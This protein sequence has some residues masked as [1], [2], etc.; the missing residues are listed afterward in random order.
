LRRLP[1]A[2]ETIRARVIPVFGAVL[3]LIASTGCRH[4]SKGSSVTVPRAESSPIIPESQR[5]LSTLGALPVIVLPVQ[6]LRGADPM[7]WTEQAGPAKAYLAKVDE[8]IAV[9]LGDRG[10]RSTWVFP[11]DLVRSARRNPGYAADPYSLASD[12][13]RAGER[14]TDQPLMEP[15]ASQLRGLVALNNTRYA[16]VPL[17][18]RFERSGVDVTAGAGGRAVLHLVLVDVRAARVLWWTD[19][20]SDNMPR[21]SPA[22]ATSVASHFADL[23]AAP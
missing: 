22:L 6:Q 17:E 2:G 18:L 15:L 21:F 11:P 3:A 5:P 8:E 20:S 9:A 7:G 19:I 1:P 23:I 12:Q 13:L 10:V 4:R 14:R 16:L